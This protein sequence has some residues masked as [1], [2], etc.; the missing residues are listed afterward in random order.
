M[1]EAMSR[2]TPTCHRTIG[3]SQWYFGK[4]GQVERLDGE[5]P[6]ITLRCSAWVVATDDRRF[7]RCG[8]VAAYGGILPGVGTD[9]GPSE[10]AILDEPAWQALSPL[11][12]RTTKA[13]RDRLPASLWGDDCGERE[14]TVRDLCGCTEAQ[15]LKVRNFA[16]RALREVQ[17]ALELHGL[18]LSTFNEWFQRQEKR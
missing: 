13:L 10:P 11:S 9:P 5:R 16:S 3:P 1:G 6:C 18:R 8:L 14:V 15:L 2:D 7:G 12:T 17:D 4:D